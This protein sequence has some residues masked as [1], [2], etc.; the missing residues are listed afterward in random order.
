MEHVQLRNFEVS[1][2]TLRLKRRL[3]HWF[4]M[5]LQVLNDKITIRTLNE[6]L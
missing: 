4:D 2:F 5:F 3:L 6:P 1:I